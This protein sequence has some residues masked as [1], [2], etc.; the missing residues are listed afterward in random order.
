M[1]DLSVMDIVFFLKHRLGL[2]FIAG[3][4]KFIVPGNLVLG[5]LNDTPG[6]LDTSFA[7]A[8]VSGALSDGGTSVL[9]NGSFVGGV[10]TIINYSH[11]EQLIP[12]AAASLAEMSQDLC[13]AAQTNSPHCTASELSAALLLSLYYAAA[14]VS[15]KLPN[16]EASLRLVMQVQTLRG[17]PFNCLTL[18]TVFQI[19][20]YLFPPTA[21]DKNRIFDAPEGETLPSEAKLLANVP[22]FQH[23]GDAAQL[24]ITLLPD[25]ASVVPQ[26]FSVVSG[27]SAL[28]KPSSSAFTTCPFP[29][30]D[31]IHSTFPSDYNWV[32]RLVAMCVETETGKFSDIEPSLTD[33]QASHLLLLWAEAIYMR[34]ERSVV[35]PPAAMV[36]AAD[37]TPSTKELDPV[38]DRQESNLL[39]MSSK[40]T[41]ATGDS[42]FRLVDVPAALFLSTML[43]ED[44]WR[45][46]MMWALIPP[47]APL[48][49]PRGSTTS[50]SEAPSSRKASIFGAAVQS[51]PTHHPT[52]AFRIIHAMCEC[53]VRLLGGEAAVQSALTSLDEVPRRRRNSR[54]SS[55]ALLPS[56][57]ESNIPATDGTASTDANEPSSRPPLPWSLPSQTKLCVPIALP[58]QRR[59]TTHFELVDQLAT[60]LCSSGVF[61]PELSSMHAGL[62]SS[63]DEGQGTG[64]TSAVQIITLF[65]CRALPRSDP[66]VWIL[67]CMLSPDMR[68]EVV[69]RCCQQSLQRLLW[70]RFLQELHKENAAKNDGGPKKRRR[71]SSVASVT[72]TT[73]TTVPSAVAFVVDLFEADSMLTASVLECHARRERRKLRLE[74][75]RLEAQQQQEQH[76]PQGQ[77]IAEPTDLLSLLKAAFLTP[78]IEVMTNEFIKFRE[79]QESKR[80]P[81]PVPTN[82]KNVF[83]VE[84]AQLRLSLP[85]RQPGL[86]DG[87]YACDHCVAKTSQNRC[88]I[89]DAI[90][91]KLKPRKESML[92]PRP[93]VVATAAAP[94]PSQP[95]AAVPPAAPIV[96]PTDEY[97]SDEEEDI[98]EDSADETTQHADDHLTKVTPEISTR[99]K[100]VSPK[101]QD[102]T[103]P[104][105]KSQQT[106]VAATTTS[107]K[108][109]GANASSASSSNN[110]KPHPKNAPS[111]GSTA[112]PVKDNKKDK[113]SKEEES[114]RKP[115]VTTSAKQQPA[116]AAAAPS[117]ATKKTPAAVLDKKPM[118]KPSSKPPPPPKSAQRAS[119]AKETPAAGA[120][121]LNSKEKVSANHNV[122][123]MD[124][125]LLEHSGKNENIMI[126]TSD[127]AERF[128]FLLRTIRPSRPNQYNPPLQ[129]LRKDE[130]R[131]A[132]LKV[133]TE[134]N[135]VNAVSS[136]DAVGD[137][138]SAQ[139]L[140]ISVASTTPAAAKQ[141]LTTIPKQP[142]SLE[143]LETTKRE[144]SHENSSI[145]SLSSSR[146]HS[147][148]SVG[149]AVP[150]PLPRDA[151]TPT[152]APSTPKF[153]PVHSGLQGAVVEVAP[154]TPPTKLE[155]SGDHT[156]TFTPTAL[157]IT[158]VSSKVLPFVQPSPVG[159]PSSTSS[160][161]TI[162]SK[163]PPPTQ[164][165]PSS[166]GS[167][168][169]KDQTPQELSLNVEKARLSATTT[170]AAPKPMMIEAD[171]HVIERNS[172]GK[173]SGPPPSRATTNI[174]NPVELPAAKTARDRLSPS[175]PSVLSPKSPFTRYSPAAVSPSPDAERSLTK[176]TIP[177]QQK[178]TTPTRAT[179]HHKPPP[180]PRKTMSASST[181]SGTVTLPPRRR[182][183][184]NKATVTQQ[185][186]RET[187]QP[188]T[189]RCTTCHRRLASPPPPYVCTKVPRCECC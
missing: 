96:S 29:L 78:A 162:H 25:R 127:S 158:A 4:R 1:S 85:L 149:A 146:D 8:D 173:S 48:G 35:P 65:A 100:T 37:V 121:A 133:T 142:L 154:Q 124:A 171:K 31:T 156:E 88:E 12:A 13:G 152:K 182:R 57:S 147:A 120:V 92:A 83:A 59:I 76:Q 79:I 101:A 114:P 179:N 46:L 6:A 107:P 43:S 23:E 184:C 134:R 86:S 122:V 44:R 91:E 63:E 115:S 99:V 27:D 19:R 50:L 54:K 131:Q 141:P 163:L 151:R 150:A 188:L 77:P 17:R 167:F 153:K 98:E 175:P 164:E 144:D 56:S 74:Q 97:S 30:C 22:V 42:Y 132:A 70:V 157:P 180:I 68:L 170:A 24:H 67:L 148:S 135:S 71:R 116:V 95:A 159:I 129:L 111:N 10:G 64:F 28:S 113:T 117:P 169:S 102:F 47:S 87:S 123:S 36:E 21:S 58:G 51:P 72:S 69:P 177:A 161:D 39:K 90:K 106:T 53:A 66:R 52:E 84:V 41:S 60:I 40:F 105:A 136:V 178:T 119:S 185:L 38:L 55:V 49:G 3:S 187:I 15:L 26:Q 189:R 137:V 155:A 33:G 166:K 128:H 34:K 104:S 9:S 143:Q 80:T 94:Q 108:S 112:T 11:R 18:F 32:Y 45:S 168:I 126:E 61:G 125:T 73:D 89:E 174:T 62:S 130:A 103:P 165:S 138:L 7:A 75:P 2:E 183:R 139:P 181:H 82:A 110:G 140:T 20:K 109:S 118:P 16:G 176:F 172:V 186:P 93:S 160:S 14:A 81:I 145:R 5:Q